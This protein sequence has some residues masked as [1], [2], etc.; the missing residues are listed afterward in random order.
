MNITTEYSVYAKNL[1]Y[2]L[3]K[4]WLIDNIVIPDGTEYALVVDNLALGSLEIND[5][6]QI[7][8]LHH[9]G[10]GFYELVMKI[11]P[12]IYKAIGS[13]LKTVK[14]IAGSYARIIETPSITYLKTTDM[15]LDDTRIMTL[16]KQ[17][18]IWDYYPEN[19]E[20]Y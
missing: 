3:F 6:V 10:N 18:G 4:W 7:Q 16:G 9:N 14:F 15:P 5:T 8:N 17:A 1:N 13:K 2:L 19:L 11:N 12:T 20:R